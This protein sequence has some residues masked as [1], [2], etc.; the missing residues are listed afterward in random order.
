MNICEKT[1]SN[2]EIELFYVSCDKHENKERFTTP[3]CLKREAFL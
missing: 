2:I 3:N 1:P